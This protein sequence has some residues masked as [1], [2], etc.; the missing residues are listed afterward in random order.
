MSVYLY[1]LCVSVV[2][3]IYI[4]ICMGLTISDYMYLTNVLWCASVSLYLSVI[5]CPCV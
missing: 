3:C 1:D 4:I 2:E 5:L